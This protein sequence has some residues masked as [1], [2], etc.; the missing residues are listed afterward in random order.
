MTS[1][2]R[3][4]GWPWT[5]ESSAPEGRRDGSGQDRLADARHILDEQVAA[6]ERGYGRGGD[7]CLRIEQDLPEIRHEGLSECPSRHRG[8]SAPAKVASGPPSSSTR[9]SLMA[10]FTVSSHFTRSSWLGALGPE[11]RPGS[12]AAFEV[13]GFSGYNSG[14]PRSSAGLCNLNARPTPQ[15]TEAARPGP[16]A[17][18][19]TSH[20]DFFTVDDRPDVVHAVHVLFA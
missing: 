3:R 10:R 20:G 16:M 9:G 1:D 12:V 7:G 5:R 15:S 18:D 19:G 2:G 11:A 4:S 14:R 13:A 6:R 8:S 17:G